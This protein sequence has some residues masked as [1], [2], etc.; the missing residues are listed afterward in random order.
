MVPPR[1]TPSRLPGSRG[2]PSR[3][4]RY[5]RVKGCAYVLASI[6][7]EDA[8]NMRMLLMS[9]V[10]ALGLTSMGPAT[11]GFFEDG[12]AAYQA[13]DYAEALKLWRLAAEQGDADAP[14]SPRRSSWPGNGSPHTRNN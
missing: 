12:L 9:L 1:V 3:R 5:S 2:A 11:A 8:V 7:Q 14:R 13:G 10:L 4:S 6:A